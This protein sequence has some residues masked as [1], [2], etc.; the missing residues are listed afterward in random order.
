M[1]YEGTSE[2]SE[3]EPDWELGGVS[4]VGTNNGIKTS[5]N[6]VETVDD[7]TAAGT[8]KLQL[9]PDEGGS[10]SEAIHVTDVATSDGYEYVAWG[11]W[12]Q[13]GVIFTDS[14][15]QTWN[16]DRGHYILGQ[17]TDELPTTGSASYSGDVRGD[18]VTDAAVIE[19]NAVGGT[20]AMDVNFGTDSATIELD[21]TRNG[22]DWASVTDNNLYVDR[23]DSS[24]G[25]RDD[26]DSVLIGGE[27][28]GPNAEELFGGFEVSGDGGTAVGGFRAKQD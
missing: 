10:F 4:F 19:Y 7:S 20:V 9:R 2:P 14:D 15:G 17:K 1:P 6:G 22:A 21:L 16:V 24:F 13:P 3:S 18:F 28:A 25:T 23:S 12:S 11:N 27:F 8:E 26:N 5:V